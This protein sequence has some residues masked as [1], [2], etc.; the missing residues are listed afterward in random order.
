[1]IIL[2]KK[3]SDGYYQRALESE[4]KIMQVLKSENIIN[5]YD[6]LG[7]NNNYY[8]VQ[9]LCDGDLEKFLKQKKKIDEQ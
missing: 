1:M 4:I 9:E 5:F 2:V 3:R 8:I 6:V 7:S